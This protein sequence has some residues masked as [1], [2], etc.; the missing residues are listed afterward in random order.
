VKLYTKAKFRNSTYKAGDH[1]PDNLFT[2]VQHI[3]ISYFIEALLTY[4]YRV[5]KL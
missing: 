3:N 5:S 4:Y 1:K 2:D